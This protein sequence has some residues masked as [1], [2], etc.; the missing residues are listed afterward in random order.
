MQTVSIAMHALIAES[1]MRRA[2][3]GHS[4]LSIPGKSDIPP[5]FNRLAHADF[6]VVSEADPK[7]EWDDYCPAYALGI[8]TY[9]ACCQEMREDTSTADLATQW[10]VLRGPSRLKW[11]KVC[12][13]IAR[14]WNALACME[15][16][17]QL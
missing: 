15:R 10:E 8:L 11:E 9:E 5:A 6:A 3:A 17:G 14:S 2:M 16:A 12:A 7:A 13:I 1:Q 4:P